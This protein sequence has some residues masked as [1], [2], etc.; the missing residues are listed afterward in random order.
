[1][2]NEA[3]GFPQIHT[4]CDVIWPISPGMT[5]PPRDGHRTLIDSFPNSVIVLFDSEFCYRIVEPETL[6]FSK[7]E[8]VEM[9]GKTRLRTVS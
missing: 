8:A 9:V 4:I 7:R 3:A 1:M 6:P 5:A 2:A